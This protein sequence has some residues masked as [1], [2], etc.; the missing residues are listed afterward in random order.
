MQSN[1]ST[2]IKCVDGKLPKLKE[3]KK[4][5]LKTEGGTTIK[6]KKN[7]NMPKP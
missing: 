3:D 5:N 4:G 7:E 1:G 2:C 6:I